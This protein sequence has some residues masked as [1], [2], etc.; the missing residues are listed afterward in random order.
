M[1]RKDVATFME[2]GGY[3][4]IIFAVFWGFWAIMRPEDFSMFRR[5]ATGTVA[6]G[7]VF[8][9]SPE[10]TMGWMVVLYAFAFF[11][12][13]FVSVY[14]AYM[15]RRKEDPGSLVAMMLMISVVLVFKYATMVTKSP[16][17]CSLGLMVSII[18]SLSLS[19]FYLRR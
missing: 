5:V 2:Y 11:L 4:S 16:F 9:R 17:I 10:L 14:M 3:L 8:F 12:V 13:G 19:A 7:S 1:E 18:Q 15:V 6:G